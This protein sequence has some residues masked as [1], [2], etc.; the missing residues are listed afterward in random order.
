MPTYERLDYGSPDGSHWGGTSSDNLAFFGA[1]PAS[2]M[3]ISTAITNVS[4]FTS[5]GGAVTTWGFNA[6][7]EIVGLLN[8]VSTMARRLVSTGLFRGLD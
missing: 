8:A 3:G 2:S 7:T 6:S 1:T 4:S 5:T